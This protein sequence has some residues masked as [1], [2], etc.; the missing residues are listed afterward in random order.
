MKLQ[1]N[2]GESKMSKNGSSGQKYAASTS[3]HTS[4]STKN[5]KTTKIT[6]TKIKYSDGSTEEQVE[7]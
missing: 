1:E 6:T 7:T 4:T 5:G 3:T 2:Q